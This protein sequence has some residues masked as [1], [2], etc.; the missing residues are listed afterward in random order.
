MSLRVTP[1][2]IEALP[3]AELHVH[4]DGSLRPD[5]MLEL[6]SAADKPLPADDAAT[7]AQVM[8]ADDSA[9][10]VEYLRRFDWTLSV[11]QTPEAIERIAW[12]LAVDL[13]GENV[14]YAEVRFSPA[15]NT[16]G[17]LS[18]DEVL[19]ACMRGLQRASEETGIV[20]GVLV[21][22]IRS[23]EPAHSLAMA[24]LAVRWKGRGVVGFDLAGA[25]AGY[26]PKKHREAFDLVAAANLPVTIHAGEAYGPESIHQALHVCGA[27]RIGHGTRLEEDPDLLAYLTDFRVPLEICLTSNVQTR[28]SSSFAA[29]PLRRYFDAG[30]VVTLNTDNRLV[31]GTT[32]SQEYILAHQHHGFT[33]DELVEI[34]RM[35]FRSAF[36][37]HR[38]RE[39]LLAR[40]DGEIAHLEEQAQRA[41]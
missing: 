28:V 25:E 22:A 14:R 16:H 24:E 18:G 41:G 39:A 20:T 10:L 13:A 7:L 40:V 3:K 30:L 33:W 2:L 4:L 23:F 1:E 6:A 5:T 31:S 19:E 34:T 15:L 11:M 35:G 29:H 8:R 17:G 21:C 26:P 36:L 32:M 12:E 27:R 37:P 38:E 9:D